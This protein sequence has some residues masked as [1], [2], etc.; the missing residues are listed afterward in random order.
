MPAVGSGPPIGEEGGQMA[1]AVA[2]SAGIDVAIPAQERLIVALDVPSVDA[3]HRIVDELGDAVS[4]YKIGL[5]LQLDPELPSL[6]SRLRKD[7][8]SIFVDYKYIDVPA[9][10]E[11]GVRTA[12]R[13][14]IRFM[15]VMGQRHVVEAATRGRESADLKIFAVTL[16]TAMTE[17]DLKREYS[18]ELSL[19]E[20]VAKRAAQ[21]SALGCDGVIASANDIELIRSVAQREDFLIV[22]P[23]IRP[24]G[25]EHDDQKR[26]ATPYDAI[27]A[28]ADYLVVGRPIIRQSD[29][30]QAA[31]RIINE[32]A[33]ALGCRTRSDHRVPS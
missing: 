26:T 15:T 20:F 22:T 27:F 19:Q 33:N 32:M 23:G 13:L 5:Y 16:L 25:T 30:R 24:T 11:G 12:S 3:A 2:A 18:T 14:G 6:F 9:T 10:V 17:E 28:G 8:K 4:F 21:A 7:H 1:D 31:Q 29:K